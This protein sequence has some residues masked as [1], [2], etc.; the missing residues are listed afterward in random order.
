MLSRVLEAT[1][2]DF[3]KFVNADVSLQSNHSPHSCISPCHS[4]ASKPNESFSIVREMREL[5]ESTSTFPVSVGAYN[6]NS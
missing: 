1:Y 2:R 5:L 4:V 3:Q 6:A